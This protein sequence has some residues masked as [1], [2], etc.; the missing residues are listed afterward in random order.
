MLWVDNDQEQ[1]ET[2]YIN[3]RSTFWTIYMGYVILVTG[4]RIQGSTIIDL[5]E[6]HLHCF[7][8]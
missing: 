5:G 2:A 8:K 6:L 7:G 1:K 3:V 4:R